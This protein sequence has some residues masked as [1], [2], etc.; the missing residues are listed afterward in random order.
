MILLALLLFFALVFIEDYGRAFIRIIQE[1]RALAREREAAKEAVERY[2]KILVQA[3]N[4]PNPDLMEKITTEEELKRVALYIMFN[5]TNNRVLKAHLDELKF[6]EV[7]IEKKRWAKVKTIENWS[8]K[9]LD[10]KTKKIVVPVKKARYKVTYT[11]EKRKG[12]WLV[13]SLSQREQ[14]T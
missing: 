5:L 13:S 10:F 12:R 2:N 6:D 7:K 4:R 3:Y 11:L 1:R 8:Y 14:G 9:Y